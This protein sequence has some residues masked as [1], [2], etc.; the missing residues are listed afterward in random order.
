MKEVGLSDRKGRGSSLVWLSV[1]MLWLWV[2]R[3]EGP[4]DVF[5]PFGS[6]QEDSVVSVGDDSSCQGPL[7][8]PVDIFA[9]STLFVSAT[10]E[11][12]QLYIVRVE[13][14]RSADSCMP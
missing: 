4:T 5:Y 3:C 9:S 1:G 6:D 12:R 10:H 7:N 2:D 11:L 8:V 13:Y 14:S